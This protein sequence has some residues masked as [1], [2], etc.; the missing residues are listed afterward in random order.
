MLFSE[1]SEKVPAF[2]ISF[3]VNWQL[4]EEPVE[5]VVK[6]LYLTQAKD[7]ISEVLPLPC[8][9]KKMLKMEEEKKKTALAAKI[10]PMT[11]SPI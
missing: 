5:T 6:W 8:I 4:S 11:T 3:L 10:S 7:Q 1:W 9:H 2:S